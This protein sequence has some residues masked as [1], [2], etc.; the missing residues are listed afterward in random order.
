MVIN[1]QH[2][3]G[4]EMLF[5]HVGTFSYGYYTN[6]SMMMVSDLDRR[7]HHD[8]A[9]RCLDALLKY[10]GTEGLPGNFKS[11]DGILYGAA[12]HEFGG[13]NKHHGYAMWGMAQHWRFTRD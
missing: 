7:G 10:Q 13:Y 1:C 5:P 11:K 8:L 12:K 4:T 3:R 9:E 6:E 2:E